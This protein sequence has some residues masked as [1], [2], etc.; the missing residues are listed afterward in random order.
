VRQ[1]DRELQQEGLARRPGRSAESISWRE[2]WPDVSNMF[3]F[4]PGPSAPRKKS[5][6]QTRKNV[7]PSAPADRTPSTLAAG[8]GL[9]QGL[10]A[11]SSPQTA[12]G[13]SSQPRTVAQVQIEAHAPIV[14]QEDTGRSLSDPT[15]AGASF[16][17]DTISGPQDGSGEGPRIRRVSFGAPQEKEFDATEEQH[18]D[19]LDDGHQEDPDGAA[20]DYE[21]QRAY[22]QAMSPTHDSGVDEQPIHDSEDGSDD[23][24][25]TAGLLEDANAQLNEVRRACALTT[26][27]SANSADRVC[28]SLSCTMRATRCTISSSTSRTP[29]LS[30]TSRSQTRHFLTSAWTPMTT[31]RRFSRYERYDNASAFRCKR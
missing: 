8:A 1:G 4:N 14:A 16:F 24:D 19:L 2:R 21:H 12:L 26:S 13:R 5:G 30:L 17:G 31:R 22:G 28:T 7:A 20:H 9:L 6:K 29:S 27:H 18:N 10:G 11:P 25:P 15:D 23:D 3:R